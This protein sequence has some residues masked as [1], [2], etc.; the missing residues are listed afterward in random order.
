MMA[1]SINYPGTFLLYILFTISSTAM[2]YLGVKYYVSYFQ[3]FISIFLWLGLWF[4]LSIHLVTGNDYVEATG[5]FAFSPIQYDELLIVTS[6]SQLVV[7]VVWIVMSVILRSNKTQIETATVVGNSIATHKKSKKDNLIWIFALFILAV[8]VL[9]WRYKILATGL[10]AQEM[11]PWPTSAVISWLLGSGLPL[12]LAVL[13]LA[14]IVGRLNFNRVMILVLFE[15]VLTSITTLSRGSI[16][17]HVGPVLIIILIN[18]DFFRK[19]I[20]KRYIVAF[21]ILGVISFAASLVIANYARNVQYDRAQTSESQEVN[22]KDS[23]SQVAGLVVDRWLGI[24]G[25]MV[26]IGHPDTGIDLLGE[27]IM[28]KD[29]IGKLQKY[30]I[31]ADSIYTEVELDIFKVGTI[32]GVLGFL[33]LGNSI[34]LTMF[35]VFCFFSGALLIERIIFYFNRNIFVAAYM[36]MWLANS[37]AQFGS[38]PRLTFFS[39]MINIFG[40]LIIS[41]VQSQWIGLGKIYRIK[42]I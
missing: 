4:K 40:I 11:L 16:L 17:W 18:W 39:L 33:Y 15:G 5:L 30:Q 25:L 38:S 24:E 41:L 34:S 26:A 42:L 2:L 28:E 13:L 31:I 22:I 6:L 19:I 27:L 32:P 36:G 20:S 12:M 23:V 7:C 37:V 21:A 35:G 8:N 29:E 1:A 3:I 10:N 9:N 14:S